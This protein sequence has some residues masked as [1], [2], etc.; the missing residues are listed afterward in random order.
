M[1]RTCGATRNLTSRFSQ[2]KSEEMDRQRPLND[3]RGEMIEKI[4]DSK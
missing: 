3:S 4:K 1:R 2:L